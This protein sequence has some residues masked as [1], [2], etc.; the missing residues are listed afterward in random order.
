MAEN[1]IRPENPRKT[2]V[3]LLCRVEEGNAYS[4]LV[5]D[6]HFKRSRMDARDTAFCTALF[7]G[8]LERRLTFDEI[9][10]RYI[11]RS[12]D[13]LSLEVRNIIR[14]AMYQL[15][16]MDSVPDSAAVNEAVKLASKNRNP[17]VKG[18]V[19]GVL[20]A[21][22]R[23]E[24][25][26][27]EAKGTAEELSV[28]YSCPLPLVNKW[29]SELGEKKTAQLLDDSLGRAPV[30]IRTNTTR[31]T[32]DE[33]AEKLAAEGLTVYK[34]KYVGEALE[35]S[36]AAPEKTAAYAEGLFHV[37]DVSCMLCCKALGAEPGMTV[38]DMCAA[39]GGKT[40]TIA[41][42][43]KN[44]GSVSAFDLHKKR[45]GLIAAGAERLGLTIISA[46]ENDA[47]TFRDDLPAADRVLCDVPCSGLGVIRRKPEIK[48]KDLTEFE[49]LPEVQY[50]IL[51]VSS[52][53]VKPG[54]VL[55]YSTCTV[56]DAENIDVVRKFL[57]AHPEFQPAA[58][59]EGFGRFGGE[60]ALT[61]L[62]EYFGSDGFFIAKLVRTD[63]EVQNA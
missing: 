2:A 57:E 62:P 42:M 47:K 60:T 58:F 51:D 26:L 22:I 28:K 11:T 41:E 46:D 27:P 15:L 40:F 23:D 61:V 54:G 59:G 7:Y 56:S 39:P 63:R 12:G 24:K 10:K 37:Q 14:T 20:R 44:S 43:M 33:L 36:G 38:L 19:N 6:E 13:K 18:F 55:V 8:T 5:L 1:T 49:R 9:I 4:N 48:Y 16:Y 52:R 17:A 45:A 32:P 29:L 25:R 21:F 30:T 35:I 31:I 34:N 3:K 53:Y 50:E